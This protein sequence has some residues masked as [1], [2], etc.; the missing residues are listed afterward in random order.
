[1]AAAGGGDVV[2]HVADVDDPERPAVVERPA[3][4]E[5]VALEPAAD[6]V[7]HAPHRVGRVDLVVGDGVRLVGA[8]VGD[9]EDGDMGL[10]AV[11]LG[12]ERRVEEG[13]L[14]NARRNGH[15]RG[16]RPS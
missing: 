9:A 1:M 5:V 12:H 6:P 7:G 3:D 15:R 2:G 4:V 8:A 14:R 16:H 10:E 13:L 11:E